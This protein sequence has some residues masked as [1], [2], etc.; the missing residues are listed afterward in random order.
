MANSSIV[1]IPSAVWLFGSA[2]DRQVCRQVNAA[3][4]GVCRDLT[5]RTGLGQALDL[6]SL[7]AAH[8]TRLRIRARGEDAEAA[9]EALGRLIENPDAIE[10]A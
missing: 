7:A 3:S 6:L 5:G 10:G 8:G 2:N 1:P 4:G 9:I